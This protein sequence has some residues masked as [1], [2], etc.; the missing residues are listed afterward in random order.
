M[1]PIA[2]VPGQS[3]LMVLIERVPEPWP[4]MVQIE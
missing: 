3:L 1:G 4:R 2:L